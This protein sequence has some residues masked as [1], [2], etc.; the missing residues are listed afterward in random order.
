[1]PPTY[2]T[3]L[4]ELT[5]AISNGGRSFSFVGESDEDTA[6][7]GATKVEK[8]PKAAKGNERKTTGSYY[9]PDSLVQL[10]LKETLD[11]VIDRKVAEN[12]N[13][14][15]ALL[16]LKVI[17]PACGSGH[18][19]VAA[20]NHIARRLADLRHAGAPTRTQH[21]HEL[22]E[23]ARHC[24]HGVDRNP[25]A[26]ELC[27]VALW[28]EVL[29]PGRPLT[30]LD[31]HICCGDSLIGVFDS[32]SCAEA[33]RTKPLSRLRVTTGRWRKPM[34]PSTASSA[35]ARRPLVSLSSCAC[36]LR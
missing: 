14:P 12:P 35:M 24:I 16:A 8:K 34:R 22:R 4:L 31:S 1:M 2:P 33:Y 27:K 23:V 28:I 9:T 26:V 6:V 30:F 3:L 21:R 29:E 17:D 20:A 32:T 11:P 19:L 36:P 10:L 15:E 5:P 25:M 13:N 18:F 7:D